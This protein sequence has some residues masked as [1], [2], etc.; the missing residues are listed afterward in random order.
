MLNNQQRCV[1]HVALHC[2]KE[3]LEKR[4]LS[5]VGLLERSDIFS[6]TQ[7][8]DIVERVIRNLERKREVKVLLAKI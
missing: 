7:L 5:D 1:V 2:Y 8:K 6:E 4:L 3:E